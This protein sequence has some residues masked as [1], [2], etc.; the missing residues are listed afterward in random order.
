MMRRE[1]YLAVVSV[2][3]ATIIAGCGKSSDQQG[4]TMPPAAVTIAP[5]VTGDVPVY[6]DEI[7]KTIAKEIVTI[8]PQVSGMLQARY[9][10]DGQDVTKGQKLFE[11]DPR[12]FQAQLDAAEASLEQNQANLANAQINFNRD[13]SLLET[14]A[15][16][17]QDYDNAQNTVA[18]ATANV[19]SS[20]AQIETATLNLE[21]CTITSPVDG[22]ASQRLVDPGNV[23]NAN[24][25]S[26]LNIQK[27]VPIDVDFTIPELE[28]SRVRQNM[29]QGTLRV[30]VHTQD[31]P[32]APAEG[33]VIFLDNAIQDGT[34][35]VRLRAT[36]PNTDRRFWPG[37]FVQVRLIL[38][39]QHDAV[40][41]PNEAIQ[42]GQQGPYVF[43]LKSDGTA[44]QR[45]V[46][47]GQRQG[48]NI[49][50][51][52]GLD[53]GETVI[54]SG[55]LMV[56]P[57]LPVNVTNPAATQPAGSAAADASGGGGAKP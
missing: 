32:E 49:V 43:V 54:Q 47:L 25:T 13:A 17:Q 53:A 30:Q 38:K 8:Q 20:E 45:Q 28:L 50:V 2:S 9:F 16:S 14:K 34:G 52:K 26:L 21:Y 33:D 51:D 55:Q 18:V 27:L 46:S 3:L 41:I 15:V 42:V 6:L 36:L 37:Q 19:K 44:E 39:T 31:D 57:G 5:V 11:I 48:D 10:T 12:P 35:T 56:Q 1:I 40:M 29:A 22:R 24:S 4:F 7:G 23:V